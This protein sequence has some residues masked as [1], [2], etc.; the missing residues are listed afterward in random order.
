M[1]VKELKNI[2]EP[3]LRFIW[4]IKERESIRLKR[5]LGFPKPWTDNEILQQFKFCNVRRSDDR[6]SRWL[7]EEYYA[8]HRDHSNIL[9]AC[10]LARFLNNPDALA[11]IGFPKVWNP[12]RVLA[13]MEKRLANKQT[14][15]SGAYLVTGSLGGSK[16]EQVVQKIVDPLHKAKIPF[17][18]TAT[19]EE[20]VGLLES[21]LGIGSFLA[22]Q[23][24]ADLHRVAAVDWSDISTYAPKGPGSQRGLNRLY[25]RE[26]NQSISKKQFAK[27]LADFIT[28]CQCV[29]SDSITRDMEGID[30]QNCLCECD[31]MERT[32]WENRRPKQRY[33]GV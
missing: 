32:L 31:K 25:G 11:D 9:T 18:K 5:A 22:G 19:M 3:H 23:I 26:L 30:Y 16:A 12:S 33:P 14:V 6:V 2:A 24:A 27:E 21:R 8:P 4:W 20:M 28:Y 29:L 1:N 13:K 7:F 10:T 17:Y 15:F